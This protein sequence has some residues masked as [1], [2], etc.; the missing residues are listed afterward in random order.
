[1]TVK[2]EILG[3]TLNRYEFSFS[4]KLPFCVINGLP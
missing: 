1:L 4:P 3:V 2:I